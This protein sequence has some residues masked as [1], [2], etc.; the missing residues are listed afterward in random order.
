MTVYADLFRYRELFGSLF[1]RDM[2]AKYKGSV[3]GLAWSLAHPVVLMLVYLLVFSVML[4]LQTASSTPHYWLFLLAGLPVWVFFATSLQAASRSLL[5]NANLIRKVR[6]PRQLVPLSIVA[7]QLVGFAVML[8][9]VVG[10]SLVFVPEAR[11][12]VWLALPLAALAVCFVAGLALAVASLNAVYRDVEHLVAALLLP[13]FFLTPVLYALEKI[14][15]VQEHPRL[16][17]LV[18]WGNPLTP[19]IEAIR[20]PLFFGVLP[21][22]G[23][24]IYL[25]VSAVLALALGA[26]VFGRLD[27]RVAVEV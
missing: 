20:D 10:L 16:V 2:R 24:A 8:A 9:I 12:T 17:D 22:A 7:T 6:F 4:K 1:R 23:D 14:P 5:E 25:A 27:D 11:G 13:W 3:L 15:G 21:E 18:H 19:A 26:F